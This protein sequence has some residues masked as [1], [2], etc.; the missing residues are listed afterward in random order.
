MLLQKSMK[1]IDLY[2]VVTLFLSQVCVDVHVGI[3][4]VSVLYVEGRVGLVKEAIL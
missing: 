3:N 1:L 4:V 2:K